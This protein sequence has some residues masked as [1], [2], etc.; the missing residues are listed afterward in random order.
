MLTEEKPPVIDRALLI[1]G[2]TIDRKQV[3]VQKIEVVI[4]FLK[5]HLILDKLHFS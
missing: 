5:N 3:N 2:N 1:F 4:T